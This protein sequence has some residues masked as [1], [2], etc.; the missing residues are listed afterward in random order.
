MKT[1]GSRY[2]LIPSCYRKFGKASE[3][4]EKLSSH[5]DA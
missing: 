2:F 3:P 1:F 5:M 4:M